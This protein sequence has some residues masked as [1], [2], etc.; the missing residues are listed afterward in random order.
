MKNFFFLFF[1][2]LVFNNCLLGQFYLGITVGERLN[3]S[4]YIDPVTSIYNRIRYTNNLLFGIECGYTFTKKPFSLHSGLEVS[5]F[6][7]LHYFGLF[8]VNYGIDRF[9]RIR[10]SYTVWEVPVNIHY[11]LAKF[12]EKSN[13]RVV[14][15]FSTFFSDDDIFYKTIENTIVKYSE[16][17]KENVY[18]SY[19][20]QRD[21]HKQG[22]IA[23]NSGF[24]YEQML[25]RK[26]K[27]TLNFQY[28]MGL[29]PGT[30]FIFQYEIK[31]SK[32]KT[33]GDAITYSKWDNL[34]LSASWVYS[35][36]R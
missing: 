27:C 32:T 25:N 13:L 8:H 33:Y 20:I 34:S 30:V 29:T 21:Y 14:F 35:L 6:T 9:D 3:Q 15:G 26:M 23:I 10:T 31:D 1:I 28:S 5:K 17:Y 19:L 18:F 16:L 11:R 12:S 22:G 36:G 7:N 2:I 4:S 24:R